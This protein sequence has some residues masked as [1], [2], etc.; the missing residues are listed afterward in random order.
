[1]K[2]T[3]FVRAPWLTMSGDSVAAGKSLSGAGSVVM[4]A[5][6]CWAKAQP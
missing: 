4:A 3:A 6:T 1:M 5:G 2:K